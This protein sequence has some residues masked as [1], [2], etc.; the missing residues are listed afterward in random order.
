LLTK[1]NLVDKKLT[2]LQGQGSTPA[3]CRGE[4]L[5]KDGLALAT[6]NEKKYL[7]I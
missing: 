6:S 4:G 3:A 1:V 7:N 5:H 2:H